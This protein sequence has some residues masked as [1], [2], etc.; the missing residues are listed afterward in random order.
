MKYGSD[1]KHWKDHTRKCAD[2]L[3]FAETGGEVPCDRTDK[4]EKEGACDHPIS[5]GVG[6]MGLINAGEI[7]DEHKWNT[8]PKPSLASRTQTRLRMERDKEEVRERI[9]E[10]LLDQE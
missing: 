10:S 9:A 4:F 3:F 2:C 7:C 8:P 1:S 6:V 5:G